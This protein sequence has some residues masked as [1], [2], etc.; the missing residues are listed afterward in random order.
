MALGCSVVYVLLASRD[1]NACWL[2]AAV[3]SLLWAHQMVAVYNLISDA[4]LQ[5]FY[6]VMAGVGLYRWRRSTRSRPAVEAL[7]S[8]VVGELAGQKPPILRMTLGEHLTV[9]SSALLLG[10]GLANFVL[11]Y[12]ADAAMPY[13]DGITT[14]FSVV[15]TFL[16]IARRLENWLYFVVIDL[17][18]VFI[19]WRTEAYLYLLV[20]LL[21][22]V[23]AVYGYLHWRRLAIHSGH[24][25]AA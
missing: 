6:F 25:A 19:Y 23:V 14:A 22:I 4:L 11:I 18:Y 2:F 9:A 12:R 15:A 17:A 5:V 16:L 7:D 13:L 8:E 10:Y 20:M 21:Y 3:G 24:E 1:R